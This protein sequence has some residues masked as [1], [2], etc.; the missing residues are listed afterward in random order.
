M[1][2]WVAEG[3]ASDVNDFIQ[4]P[5]PKLRIF[6]N[7]AIRLFFDEKTITNKQTRLVNF[8]LIGQKKSWKLW[9]LISELVA[10]S[11][12]QDL[13]SNLKQDLI[14]ANPFFVVVI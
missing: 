1:K 6:T 14:I 11:G 5:I 2:N 9:F 12:E 8:L 3:I 4:Q 10:G 13:K 7:F